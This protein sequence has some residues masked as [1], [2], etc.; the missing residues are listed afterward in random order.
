MSLNIFCC[1]E[2]VL[3]KTLMEWVCGQSSKRIKDIYA[4]MDVVAYYKPKGLYSY[5][6][7]RTTQFTRSEYGFIGIVR[8]DASFETMASTIYS[9][10]QICIVQEEGNS[11][12]S[13][14]DNPDISKSMLVRVRHVVI[15]LFNKLDKEYTKSDRATVTKVL[16]RL[17]L[18]LPPRE[19]YTVNRDIATLE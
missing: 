8:E 1:K 11:F 18:D 12:I 10:P 4:G 2:V 19:L 17:V 6:L 14:A 3:T 16:E 13:I 9:A 5:V 7:N 15:A